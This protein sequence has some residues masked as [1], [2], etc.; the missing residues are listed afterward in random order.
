MESQFK[1]LLDHFYGFAKTYLGL[2]REASINFVSDPVNS[3]D[4]LGKTAFYDPGNFAVTIYVDGRHP[5]DILRSISHELVHH[6]QNCQGKM[7]EPLSTEPG[8][9][10]SNEH[11]RGLEKEAYLVGNMCFRDWE[12]KYKANREIKTIYESIVRKFIKERISMKPKSELR[13]IVK[14]AVTKVLNK[15]S[16]EEYDRYGDEFASDEDDAYFADLAKDFPDMGLGDEAPA[17]VADAPADVQA[18]MD[19]EF[20][21][22]EEPEEDDDVMREGTRELFAKIKEEFPTAVIKQQGDEVIATLS[23]EEH[24]V[25]LQQDPDMQEFMSDE[26][27]DWE[28]TDN[29][30]IVHTGADGKNEASTEKYDD[31][32]ELKGDQD[33]LPDHLQK[34][35]ISDKEGEVEETVINEVDTEKVI[36]KVFKTVRLLTQGGRLRGK[37]PEEAH[38]EI[39]SVMSD[40]V[41]MGHGTPESEHFLDKMKPEEQMAVIQ[42]ATSRLQET[43]E[44]PETPINEVDTEA[45]IDKVFKTVRLLTQGG[46]L[47]GKSPE[48]AHKEIT[49]VMSDI[50]LM[51]HGTPESEHFLDKMKPE[52]QMAV[53]QQ[54]TSRL[55]EDASMGAGAVEVA[56]TQSFET[57]EDFYS[58]MRDEARTISE[59]WNK[60]ARD[61]R[62]QMLNERLMKAWKYSK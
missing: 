62:N 56:P 36:E 31:A 24:I 40:I 3:S 49:S 55:Q 6:R 46:R 29:G 43:S 58:Q 60:S 12:D 28:A 45:V 44:T 17:P 32:P 61:K 15:R 13:N 37:S 30:F 2:D 1:D 8:Y 7:N 50:V 14:E 52:E 22:K 33:E 21:S 25:A 19:D 5:K 38:K 23:N 48:E 20:G 39:T 42:Q 35:I 41:L 10:Q 53:I 27:G 9:A 11:L 57:E 47:R 4:A 54:A 51:G 34:A 16:L 59:D 18:A 26:F